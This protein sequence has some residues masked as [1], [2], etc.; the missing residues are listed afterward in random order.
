[1]AS[2]TAKFHRLEAGLRRLARVVAGIGVAVLLLQAATI[3]LDAGARWL[4]G[5]PLHGME[6]VNSLVIG[7]TIAS[8]LPAL[9]ME[10]GNIT[11]M[12]LGRALGPRASAWLDLFGQVLALAFILLLAWQYIDYAADLGPRHSV[13]LKLPKQP[14]AWAAAL[15]VAL[16]GVMQLAVVVTAALHAARGPAE[17]DSAE[18]DSGAV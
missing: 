18:S 7:A 6:D 5:A 10:R 3:V 15:L 8:F 9:F 4:L 2:W 11:I 17:P 13:I 12:L 1:M 14:A 16:A